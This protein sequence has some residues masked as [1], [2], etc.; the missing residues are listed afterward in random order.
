M[1]EREREETECQK[2][3]QKQRHR[4][5]EMLITFT[6]LLKRKITVSGPVPEST[7]VRFTLKT[8]QHVAGYRK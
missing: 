8:S 6:S 4:K 5:R 7:F 2:D 1:N 3:R